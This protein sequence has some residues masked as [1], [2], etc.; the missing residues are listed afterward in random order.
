MTG[1]QRKSFSIKYLGCPLYISRRKKTF[2][3]NICK[4]IV[5]RD[6][7][8]KQRRLS[9]GGKLVLIKDV[10]SLMPIHLLAV[11]SPPKGMFLALE[12]VFAG[13]LWGLTD[14]GSRFHWIKWH[15][16]CRPY[17]EGGIALRS[18][19]DVLDA[20]F[21]KFWWNFMKKCC[22]WAELMHL[23]YYRGGHP[24]LD[25]EVRF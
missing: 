1:F 11:G 18:I 2:Y 6:L 15:D 24:C 23:K 19:S 13:F 16:L 12:I 5:Q 21:I 7:S 9:S 3:T 10:L 22:L 8:W 17:E 14:F 25:D 20:F 4:A